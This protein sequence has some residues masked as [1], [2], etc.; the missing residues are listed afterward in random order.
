[1]VKKAS[2]NLSQVVQNHRLGLWILLLL[3]TALILLFPVR[4]RYEYHAIESVYAFGNNLPIFGIL[5]YIWL[6]TLL[7]LL[8]SKG[9]NSEWQRVALVCIFALVFFGFWAINTPTGGH[10]DH[11]WQM[12]HI[13][14]ILETGSIAPDHLNLNYFQFPGFHIAVS[15]LSLIS[16]LEL[17]EIRI[18]YTIFSGVL[19]TALLYLLFVNLLKDSYLSSLSVL[20]LLLGSILG[21]QQGFWPG[22]LS[23]I[24]IL[25][26]LLILTGRHANRMPGMGIPMVVIMVILLAVLTITYLPGSACFIFILVGIYLLQKVAKRKVVALTTVA[27]ILVM[28]LAWSMYLATSFFEGLAEYIPTF[29]AGFI[30]PAERVGSALTL[31]TPTPAW[32]ISIKYFWLTLIIGFGGIIGICNLVEVKKMDTIEA[33]ETGGLLGVAGFLFVSFFAIPG[34]LGQ[35]TRAM[36]YFPFFTIPIMLAF[37]SRFRRNDTISYQNPLLKEHRG[38]NKYTGFRRI[39]ASFGGWFRRHIFTLLIILLFALSFP[40]FLIHRASSSSTAIYPYELSAGEFIELGYESKELN[41]FSDVYTCIMYTYYVPEAHLIGMQVVT[42]AEDLWQKMNKLVDDFENYGNAI[43]VL[44][45]RFRQPPHQ[46]AIMESTDP[47]WV[48]IVN[49]LAENNKIYDNGQIETYE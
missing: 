46:P 30:T 18:I 16:G 6:A 3:L 34:Q 9:R 31:V 29:V 25:L 47:K 10:W 20:L 36:A 33:L 17:F 11:L 22:S 44:S 41:L 37:L 5:Y 14:Y 21:R 28:F 13:K 2:L 15:A 26:F 8:F 4:L 7:L 35:G 19:F 38:I 12:G 45:E 42:G 1:M 40:T 39:L 43:F 24:F 48:E 32:A 49:R 23:F 27:L